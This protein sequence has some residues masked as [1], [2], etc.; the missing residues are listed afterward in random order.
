MPSLLEETLRE[1]ND[2][3]V[4]GESSITIS[5]IGSSTPSQA[6]PHRCSECDRCFTQKR[7]LTRHIK[8][9]ACQSMDERSS[10]SSSTSTN[11]SCPSCEQSFS[12]KDALARHIKSGACQ[13]N[14]ETLSTISTISST[15]TSYSCSSCE[16]SFA[17]KDSLIRHLKQHHLN[18]GNSYISFCFKQITNFLYIFQMVMEMMKS[19]TCVPSVNMRLQEDPISPNTSHK[20]SVVQYHHQSPEMRMILHSTSPLLA[21][22]ALYLLIHNFSCLLTHF[23]THI[24]M[25]SMLVTPPL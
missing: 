2:I 19:G 3:S 24:Q 6:A 5:S 10:T 11:Y 18:E 4:S 15:S 25:I 8:S 1:M 13:S 17:R 16:Q 7:N 12:R 20:A 9:G 23:N 22:C 14:G 21:T